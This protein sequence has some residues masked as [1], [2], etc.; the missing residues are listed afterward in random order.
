[1]V[2]WSWF[3]NI[4]YNGV[5]KV[6]EKALN[7]LE[8]LSSDQSKEF[9]L[10]EIA[11]TLNMDHGTCA[12]IIKTLSTR[13]Y[14]HQDA[15]RRG[16]KFGYMM[17]KLTN[18]AVNNE[19]LTKM[20]REE[21]DKLGNLL[22]ETAILSCIKNDKRI[23]LYYTNPDRELLVRHN[24]AKSVYAAN[25]GRVILANYRPGH[26]EKCLIRLGL[27]TI[28][29]WPEI[30]A[31]NNPAG[32]LRNRLVDIKSTGYEIYT[33]KNGVV[34]IAA[35]LFSGG[36][37]VGSVGV[38]LPKIRYDEGDGMLEKVLDT[39]RAINDKIEQTERMRGV[40]RL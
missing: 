22:N 24:I 8:L 14:V 12:N 15:P 11:D 36:H 19:E 31:S 30:Y 3:Y 4:K 1:M 26:L 32:E 34:G 18:T 27:P 21:I 9:L 40:D 5:I 20:A 2:M 38:Y 33:D 13:G 25:T 6:I 35:P 7:I 39:A 17:F 23:V 37:V 29:E 16:Y 28:D 10:S